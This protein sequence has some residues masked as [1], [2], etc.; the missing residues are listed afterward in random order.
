MFEIGDEVVLVRGVE[1][2]RTYELETR[3]ITPRYNGKARVGSRRPQRVP[4]WPQMR[5]GWP[6]K[7]ERG[8]EMAKNGPRSLPD[9]A[10][11]IWLWVL[12]SV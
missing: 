6:I 9:K 8:A 4:R 1:G 11:S 5:P 12:A 10:E 3:D 7:V 2:V